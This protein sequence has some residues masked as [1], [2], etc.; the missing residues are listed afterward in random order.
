MTTFNNSPQDEIDEELADETTPPQTVEQPQ[1][2]II[3][4]I[5]EEEVQPPVP[6]II[7]R[8]VNGEDLSDLFDVSREDVMGDT[9]EGLADLTEVTEE[10][11]MGEGGPDMSD[12]LDVPDEDFKGYDYAPAPKPL[13]VKAPRVIVRPTTPPTTVRGQQE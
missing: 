12:L 11:V 9:D 8:E 6:K 5:P 13:K 10:D 4:E 1:V 7:T 2:P 3:E